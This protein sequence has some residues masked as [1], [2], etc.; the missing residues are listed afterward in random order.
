MTKVYDVAW[1]KV[2]AGYR[3]GVAR[4]CLGSFLAHMCL[5]PCPPC[6]Y[7]VMFVDVQG[8]GDKESP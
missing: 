7:L 4:Q 1:E 2:K 5:P 6:H 8:Y 3:K